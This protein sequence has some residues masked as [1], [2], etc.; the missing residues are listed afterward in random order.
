MFGEVGACLSICVAYF[1]R[2]VL[3]SVIYHRVLPLDVP[4]FMKECCLKMS[5]PILISVCGGIAI[6][7]F[8][9]DSGWGMLLIKAAATA[10]IYLLSVVCFGLTGT[11]I[12]KALEWIKK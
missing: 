8:I 6:N 10:L 12:R 4:G 2:A 7:N 3:S 11:E 5:V 9:P 1:V